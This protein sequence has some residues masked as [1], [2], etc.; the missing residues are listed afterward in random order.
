ML[1]G[2]TPF[3]DIDPTKVQ[4]KILD[5]KINYPKTLSHKAKDLIK[6]L[7]NVEPKKRLGCGKK[8]ICEII[9]DPF[10]KGFDWTNLLLQ[11][12]KAPYIPKT[13]DLNDFPIYFRKYVDDFFDELDSDIIVN[14]NKDPFQKWD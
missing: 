12:L 8:G 9:Y 14:K 5:G 11:N 1:V 13:G 10:F 3:E 4:Q 7:L 2:H 6:H